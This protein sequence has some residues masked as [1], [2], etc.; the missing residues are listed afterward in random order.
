MKV[1]FEIN[2]RIGLRWFLGALLVWAS[3]AKIANPAEFYGELMAYQLPLT[4][5]LVR[6]SAMVVPWLE[7]LCGVLMI[8]G[9]AQRAAVVLAAVLFGVFV[10]ATGQAWVRGLDISCGC[11]NLDFLGERFATFFE[12]VKFAF[13]RAL[14]LLAAAVFLLRNRDAATVPAVPGQ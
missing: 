12:S 9:R 5:A 1:S 4:D 7:L 2:L 13:F 10:L 6:L 14:L 11:F 8:G 3:L